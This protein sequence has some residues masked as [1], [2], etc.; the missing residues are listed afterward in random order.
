MTANRM[1]RAMVILRLLG[2]S[3]QKHPPAAEDKCGMDVGAI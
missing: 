3:A 2:C 1:F